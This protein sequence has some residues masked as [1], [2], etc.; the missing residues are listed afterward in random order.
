MH[1]PFG[2]YS[3]T[4]K[5]YQT[6]KLNYNPKNPPTSWEDITDNGWIVRTYI[7]NGNALYVVSVGSIARSGGGSALVQAQKKLAKKLPQP[8]NWIL[9]MLKEKMKTNIYINK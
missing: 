7:P 6:F 3:L 9:R 2:D 1:S 4:I 8:K 5:F